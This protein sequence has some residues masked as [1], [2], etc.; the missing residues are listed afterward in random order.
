MLELHRAGARTFD[1]SMLPKELQGEGADPGKL[2]LAMLVYLAHEYLN[3]HWRPLFITDVARDL[4][5][6]KLEFVGR[7][8]LLEVLPPLVLNDR[9]REVVADTADPVLLE[10]QTDIIA[11]VAFRRD[12]F[13]RGGLRLSASRQAELMNA[14]QI[15]LAVT[16]EEFPMTLTVL[17]GKLDLDAKV[18]GPII[19]RIAGGPASV[20]ELIELAKGVGARVSAL[21]I[22]AVL[23]GCGAAAPVVR[24]DPDVG[25]IRRFNAAVVE[26]YREQ[27]ALR[28]TLASGVTGAGF[29][30]PLPQCLAY[31]LA[32]GQAQSLAGFDLKPLE[33]I[34]SGRQ[35]FWRRLGMM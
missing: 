8:H 16:P 9:Q 34:A 6:A 31:L 24:T 14:V 15:V 18:Y 20:A 5:E 28:F 11:P 19:A 3:E 35:D 7:S 22:I 25:A 1:T 17:N 13:V 30:A 12:L 27:A 26:S 29:D 4:A 10:L 33:E 32:S 23:V 21:E 2:P